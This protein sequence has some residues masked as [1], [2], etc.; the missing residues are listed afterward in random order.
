MDYGLIYQ[1][2]GDEKYARKAREIL[3][4]YAERYLTYPMHNNQGKPGKGGRVA[5]QSLTEASWLIDMVQG[6]DLVWTTL[7]DTDRKAIA[8]KLLRPALN[9]IILKSKL[10]IH[11]IQCRL[12]SA[13]GL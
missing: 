3:L 4:A 5:S 10:G 11:N 13:I 1:V 8:D 7:S 9:E 12:N 2:T 6:A